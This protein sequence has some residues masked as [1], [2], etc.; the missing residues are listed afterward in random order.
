MANAI[1]F[2]SRASD[3]RWSHEGRWL[4]VGLGF[5]IRRGKGVRM[6][7]LQVHIKRI[8]WHRVNVNPLRTK[9]WILTTNKP[10]NIGILGYNNRSVKIYVTLVT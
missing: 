5:L 4:M 1:I 2:I 3:F 9:K 6:H 7:S 8:S 10:E